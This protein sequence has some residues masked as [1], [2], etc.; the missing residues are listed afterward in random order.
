MSDLGSWKRLYEERFQPTL[1]R[2][3]PQDSAEH[4]AEFTT[5]AKTRWVRHFEFPFGGLFSALRQLMGLERLSYSLADGPTLVR[6][7]VNTPLYRPSR[8]SPLASSSSS[9]TSPIIDHGIR[10]T[11]A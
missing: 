7:K 8:R 11:T 3:L 4:K 1:D 9:I 10:S 5:R 6:T 2:R